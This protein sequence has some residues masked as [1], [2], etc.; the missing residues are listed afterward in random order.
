MIFER[1]KISKK[2]FINSVTYQLC[3]V[4]FQSSKV[5][6]ILIILLIV[7]KGRCLFVTHCFAF[8]IITVNLIDKP[9]FFN[10]IS[11]DDGIIQ[12]SQITHLSLNLLIT[13]LVYKMRQLKLSF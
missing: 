7:G 4:K 5:M 6:G 8:S 3:L 1:M 13:H 12:T 2:K 10:D 9:K 11:I